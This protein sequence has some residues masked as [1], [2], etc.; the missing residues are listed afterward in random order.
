ME[1]ELYQIQTEFFEGPLDLLLY[2]IKKKKMNIMD[3]KISEITGEYLYYLKN[4][5]GINPSRE[6][7]FLMTASTLIYIKSRS[8]LPRPEI[9]Q[10]E[11]PE[12]K[13]RQT[14]IEYERVQKISRLLKELEGAEILLWKREEIVENFDS[15]EFDIESISPF[16]LAEVFLNIVKR[17]EREEFLYIETK[18][19]SVEEKLKEIL[20]LLDE[21]GYIN[22]SEYV[23]K[24]DSIEEILV[25]FFTLLEMI[26]QQMVMA[27]QK[28]LFDS[29]SV[30]KNDGETVVQ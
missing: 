14:L 13:L 1:S 17:K 20:A 9:L 7:D 28:S 27:I 29:I 5:Q 23:K 12:D 21:N 11:S 2:L 25:S 26:K 8:L 16:Q 6:G 15:K 10:E 4:T 18:N 3:V 19:Y 24:L 30:W 22:F